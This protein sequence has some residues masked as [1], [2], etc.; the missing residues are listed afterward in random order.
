MN[1]KG[2]PRHTIK[3]R[4]DEGVLMKVIRKHSSL[5]ANVG[6]Y[7]NIS[8]SQSCNPKGLYK[9]LPLIRDLLTLEPTGE[10]HTQSLRNA[11]FQVLLQDPSLNDSKWNGQVWVGLKVERLGVILYHMRRLLG[12]DLKSCAAKLTGCEYQELQEVVSIMSPK[13]APVPT[14]FDKRAAEEEESNGR[15][16]KKE[17]SDVSV[18]SSG[19]PKCFGTPDSLLTKEAFPE[20]LLTKEA[21][22][23]SLLTKEASPE[24]IPLASPSFLRRRP[25]QLVAKP[26]SS[27]QQAA[28][29]TELGLG[30]KKKPAGKKLV[31]KK[32]KRRRKK[33]ALCLKGLGVRQAFCL[34]A[35]Q[36][37]GFKR[38]SKK[39]G[40]KRNSKGF[41][42]DKREKTTGQ[43]FAK[44]ICSC[45][46]AMGQIT[47]DQS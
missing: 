26:S 46:E 36:K 13:E 39:E 9:L 6:A 28:L 44:R 40:F 7:E 41:F 47:S 2:G 21:S 24:S 1:S 22:P 12:S 5:L 42:F 16:L 30:T 23:E 25:G 27:E 34:K 10:I 19:F 4:L 38:D 45:E 18:D 43:I 37:K 32:K 11:I 31:K 29:R 8:K 33:P 35:K 20:S 3:P 15:K 14:A 17:I